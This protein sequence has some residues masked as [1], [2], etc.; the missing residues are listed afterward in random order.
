M[1]ESKDSVTFRTATNDDRERVVSLIF[2]VLIEHGLKPAP[3]STDAD[4]K[5]IEVNYL[6]TGGIFELV[7][8]REGNLL[9][10]V[11]LYPLDGVTC[12]LRKM[13]LAPQARGLGLGRHI[14][15]RTI[16]NARRL[17][18]RRVTLETASVLERAVRLYTRFGFQPVHHE[19]LSARADRAFALDLS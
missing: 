11:G 2:T 16:E 10:T 8:D 13:Y 6:K 1:D 12:E 5:D 3:E 15:E 7:E 14:L 17:G 19:R 18:F 9:G 4:L